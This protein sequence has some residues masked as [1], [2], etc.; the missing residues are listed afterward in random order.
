MRDVVLLLAGG[1]ALGSVLS[2][3]FSDSASA[4]PKLLL[5]GLLPAAAVGWYL[6]RDPTDL[7]G[8]AH[9][10]VIVV[11]AAIFFAGY[12]LATLVVFAARRRRGGRS[13]PLHG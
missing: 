4:F 1:F 6:V 13:T 10:S 9:L 12:A 7:E 5:V 11:V 2:F 3:L 8:V